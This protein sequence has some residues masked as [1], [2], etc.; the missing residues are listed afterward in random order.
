[1]TE[2][3]TFL[4]THSSVSEMALLAVWF[5][6]SPFRVNYVFDL[7]EAMFLLNAWPLG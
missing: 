2:N 6:W 3:A 5:Q 1:M 7:K 4:G